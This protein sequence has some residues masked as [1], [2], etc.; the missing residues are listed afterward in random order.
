MLLSKVNDSS[1]SSSQNQI[2]EQ[3][4]A[5]RLLA[6]DLL[7]EHKCVYT[8][9]TCTDTL[10]LTHTHTRLPEGHCVLWGL[11][12]QGVSD[13]QDKGLKIQKRTV[14]PAAQLPSRFFN[15]IFKTC[16]KSE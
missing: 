5:A 10:T 1:P 15:D 6:L 8:Q 11:R 2:K 9:T 3:P 4:V 7:G 14:Q 16:Q 13:I 12:G